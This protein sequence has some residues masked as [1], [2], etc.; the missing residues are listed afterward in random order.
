MAIRSI[1]NTWPQGHQ[2][3]L[4]EVRGNLF[5]YLLA[6]E[7][8]KSWG[9]EGEFFHN[10][11]PKIT[12][13]LGAYQ[14]FLLRHSPSLL[15]KLQSLARA[16]FP[17]LQR[18]LAPRIS[19]LERVK[20]VGKLAG[21]WDAKRIG[22]ADI[23]LFCSGGKEVGVGVK[24]ATDGSFIN[25]KSGGAKSFLA[26]YFSPFPQALSLQKG[27]IGLIEWSYQE[28]LAQISQELGLANSLLTPE[29]LKGHLDSPLPGDQGPEVRA[30]IN[31][32]YGRVATKIFESFSLLRKEDERLWR[33]CLWP[34][35]GLGQK[36]GVSFYVLY[37]GD[38]QLSRAWAL[39][40]GLVAGQLEQA[41]LGGPPEGKSHFMVQAP[42][43]SLQIRV[44]PMGSFLAKSYKMN[45]SVKPKGKE[46]PCL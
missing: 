10:Q 12:Q 19:G 44:K 32:H 4:N 26:K 1:E 27:L 14:D 34:L 36:K 22:E 24:M 21:P 42:G 35:F 6:Y 43:I 41:H 15:G 16:C 28:M 31:A 5:E 8:S 20:V 29:E 25:T 13:Q 11:S 2:A 37:R 23:L 45:C 40:E 33:Q 7:I 30:I 9:A 17:F 3:L 18:V 46:A 38:Y 39:D